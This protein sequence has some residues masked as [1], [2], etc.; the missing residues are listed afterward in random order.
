MRRRLLHGKNNLAGE[1]GEWLCPAAPLERDPSGGRDAWNCKQL[2]PLEEIVSVPAILNA[3][4]DAVKDSNSKG[5]PDDGSLTFEAVA[6]AAQEGNDAVRGVLERAAQ[7]LGWVVCQL[8]VAFN[9]E[10]V[11]LAG[12][13]V[14]LGDALLEPLRKSVAE[15]C[16]QPQQDLPVV[17]DSGLG[18]FNGALGAAALAL[19]EWKPKR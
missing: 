13:L 12:P 18:S 15:F 14:A 10:K 11:I 16:S 9:P 3:V 19:H 7:T 8:D 1:I 6:A 17:V 4:T 5:L 2:L